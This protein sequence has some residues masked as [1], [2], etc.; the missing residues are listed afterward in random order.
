MSVDKYT[1]ALQ[2]LLPPGKAWTRDPG[3]E[4]TRLLQGFA[5][6]FARIEQRGADLVDQ[7]DPRTVSE[8]LTEWEAVTAIAPAGTTGDRQRRLHGQLL[9]FEPPRKGV[10]DGIAVALGYSLNFAEYHSP[11]VADSPVTAPLFQL[12]WFSVLKIYPN[13]GEYDAAL[14]A[15]IETVLQAHMVAVFR[16]PYAE[17][18]TETCAPGFAGA[19]YGVGCNQLPQYCAVGSGGEI[20]VSSDGRSWARRTAGGS[21]GGTFRAVTHD[22]VGAWI[23][24][25]TGGE[26]QRS[27]DD[28]ETWVKQPTAGSY[29]GTFY[30]IDFAAVAGV[31]IA[32][33]AGGEIQRSTDGGATW[34]SVAAAGGYAGDFHGVCWSDSL[35]IWT[36]VGSSG[37]IQFSFNDGASWARAGEVTGNP[38]H[39]VAVRDTTLVAVGS[40]PTILSSEDGA[41]WKEET[42]AGGDNDLRAI[43]ADGF[44][45]ICALGDTWAELQVSNDGAKWMMRAPLAN[46]VY[47]VTSNGGYGLLAVGASAGI[48]SSLEDF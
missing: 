41:T 3:A 45:V 32:V 48:Y 42:P 33:G 21:Y 47:A 20:Q 38:L 12:P 1:A 25:G 34:S 6:E 28:G 36:A 35:S 4:V 18:R 19:F 9:G 44:G 5:A 40:G 29:G 2:A 26:I 39:A 31:W 13:V 37:E 14:Q 46:H 24:V 30:A 7:T 8:L 43:S 22:R 15:A 10:L 23:A 17:W 16:F 11:S 27:T